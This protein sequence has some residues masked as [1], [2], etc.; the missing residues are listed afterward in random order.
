MPNRL[1]ILVCIVGPTA[2]GKT[3]L[4]VQ[5]AKQLGAEVIS[6]DARQ[7]YKELSIG[8]AK[9]SVEEMASVQH[10]LIGHMSIN[11][12]YD[13]AD[14]ERDALDAINQIGQNQQYIVLVGGSGMY[15]NTLLYGIDEMPT[16]PDAIRQQLQTEL[17]ENGL[18]ALVAELKVADP[19]FASSLDIKNKAR[20]VRALEVIRTTGKPYSD[21][22][23][24]PRV[25]RPFQP[26]VFGL[27]WPR[28]QLYDRINQRVDL[29]FDE[30]LLDEAR[31][32]EHLQSLKAL[33]T[34]GYSELWP[35][36]R[37]DAT[38]EVAK[39]AIKQN[40]RRY[41]K[42]QLTWFRNQLPTIWVKPESAQIDILD[43][44]R[45]LNPAE[46]YSQP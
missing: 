31:H 17:L 40:T 34:I 26:I 16:V 11:E 30:G 1:P 23:T 33:Q 35:Y 3:A 37:G 8:T 27:D 32:F 28:D 36:L 38:L 7:F 14:F 25:E 13:V 15:V 9:P 22:R 5:I 10:H 44:L 46:N 45:R 20:V 24:K 19:V 42:R 12:H 39:E 6:A 21:Y 18:D 41:A 29:M 4:S 2:S 43:Y